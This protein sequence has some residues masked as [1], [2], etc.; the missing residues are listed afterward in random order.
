MCI[1]FTWK[2]NLRRVSRFMLLHFAGILA[3]DLLARI[4][5]VRARARK[6]VRVDTRSRIE[7]LAV[8]EDLVG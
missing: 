7:I 4:L 6:S 5:N 2:F 3:E 1:Y 8:N